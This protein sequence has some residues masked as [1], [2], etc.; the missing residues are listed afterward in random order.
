MFRC[1]W[2]YRK[3]RCHS[4][5]G[6]L[7]STIIRGTLL[8]LIPHPNQIQPLAQ[9]RP[10]DLQEG[11]HGGRSGSSSPRSVVAG[12]AASRACSAASMVSR[13]EGMREVSV[14]TKTRWL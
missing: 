12:S 4:F 2:V 1:G 11:R 13:V 5:Q 10:R 7:F 6:N 8:Q 9:L 14:E 3:A